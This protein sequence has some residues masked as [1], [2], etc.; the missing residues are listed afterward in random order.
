MMNGMI[1]VAEAVHTLG[2]QQQYSQSTAAVQLISYMMSYMPLTE[3]FSA[4]LKKDEVKYF[5]ASLAVNSQNPQGAALV[6][7][8]YSKYLVEQGQMTKETGD[9]STQIE[10]QKAVVRS[11]GQSMGVIYSIEAP[12]ASVEQ[13]AAR[14]ISSANY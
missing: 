9:L 3:S 13:M 14:L 5:A 11:L 10:T 6:A 2:G 7:A 8:D 12:L 1:A 4:Q